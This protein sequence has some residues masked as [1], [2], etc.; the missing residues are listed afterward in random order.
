M[1]NKI[2]LGN[3]NLPDPG[4]ASLGL[5]PQHMFVTSS[6]QIGSVIQAENELSKDLS[7][8]QRNMAHKISNKDEYNFNRCVKE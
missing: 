2:I 7:E 3:I 4:R 1:V 5:E 8:L 6:G